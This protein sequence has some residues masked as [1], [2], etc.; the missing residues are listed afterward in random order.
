V[1]VIPAGGGAPA[2]LTSEF[3]YVTRPAW[4]VDGKAV[5]FGADQNGI[6]NVFKVP[7][8]DGR[9]SGGL[10]RVTL[11]QGQ[12]AG[13]TISPDGRKLAFA[14]LYNELNVW[15]VTLDGMVG[16]AVTS[17]AGNPNYPHLSPDGKTFL[18]QS[19]QT[20]D[21]AVWTVDIQGKYLSRLTPGER[22]EPSARWSPD[23]TRFGYIFDHKLRIQS[24]GSLTAEETGVPLSGS[25]SW[26]PDGKTLALGAALSGPGEVRLY[27]VASGKLR[28]I[29]N[30]K[31]RL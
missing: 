9:R 18:V 14:A 19:N 17:G 5:Y 6:L 8:R 25:M 3:Q 4:S 13:A 24:L 28:G 22:V 15:E 1:A 7:F 11:G 2:D 30:L 21:L 16:R 20:G 31:Q 10:S 12:D 29:T 27:D 23:G 26:S